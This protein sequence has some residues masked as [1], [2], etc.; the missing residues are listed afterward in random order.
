M[1]LRI[2]AHEC[3]LVPECKQPA[4][5][6]P[7]EHPVHVSFSRENKQQTSTKPSRNIGVAV[8]W[9]ALSCLTLKKVII[10]LFTQLR[11]RRLREPFPDGQTAMKNCGKAFFRIEG[12]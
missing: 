1:Q 9:H 7:F 6:Q 12:G 8:C 5:C 2:A 10:Y 11:S 3:V 4:I